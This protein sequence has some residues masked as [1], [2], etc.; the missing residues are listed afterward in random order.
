[1]IH[2][3]QIDTHTHTKKKEKKENLRA[4]T[5]SY[6]FLKSESYYKKAPKKHPGRLTAGT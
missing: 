2:G 3:I 5:T 1:M 4:K 6:T